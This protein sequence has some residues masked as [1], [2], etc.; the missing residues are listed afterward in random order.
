MQQTERIPLNDPQRLHFEVILAS[1]EKALS[2]LEQIAQG[3]GGG[4]VPS[5]A[6]GR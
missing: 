4:R 6:D 5:H 3:N 1:L 2:R